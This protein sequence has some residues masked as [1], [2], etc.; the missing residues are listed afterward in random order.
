MKNTDN[1]RRRISQSIL[2]LA[3]LPLISGWPKILLASESETK[4]KLADL[5]LQVA[6]RA[7]QLRQARP[8]KL[9]I[10]LP[11]GSTANVK[12]A[13]DEFQ[14]LTGV[15]FEI[16]ETPVD[17]INTR[18]FLEA[19]LSRGSYDIALPA[20]FGIPDLAEAGAII[21]LDQYSS[22]YEPTDF[23]SNSLYTIGDY[24]RGQHYGYQTDGDTYLMFYNKRFLRN[25][26][27]SKSF[28]DKHGY[29][30]D[31]P[32]TWPELDALMAHFHQPE[33]GAYGGAL[34]RTPTYMLWEWWVRFHAKGFYPL[35]DNL[36]PQINNE[37]G[38][39]ALEEMI[40]ATEY[41]TPNARSNSL[42][43]NWRE[44]SRGNIFCNIGW[45][46]TQKY[47]N[48]NRSALLGELEFGPTPGGMIDGK[49]IKTSY[50]NWGWNY[51]VAT[52]SANPEIAYLFSLFA[53]SPHISTLAVR[54][55]DGFFDPF[56]TEHY[57]DE[58][59]LKTYSQA[60]LTEHHKSMANSIPDL[61]LNGQTQY[62]DALRNQI[63]IAHD[64]EKTARQ[65]LDATAKIWNRLHF[66]LGKKVQQ[67]QWRFLK[68][69]YPT[70]LK[71]ALR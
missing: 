66:K 65:A 64:G 60:F 19:Q 70:A 25:P 44:F 68:S 22:R 29:E 34:F 69:R 61:Y 4:F 47:L 10:L 28:A 18:M 51:T 37:A 3:G 36:K 30:A 31:I 17:D 52:N 54:E 23:Q 13:I 58:S 35:D 33:Q 53:C 71:F 27:L 39:D 16:I 9:T 42:F 14:A 45:G 59:I 57:E 48:S 43:D 12:P 15:E 56:R 49:S 21:P 8:V 26:Q 40:A 62:Y 24:Y 46:G 38:V 50:F 32:R 2:G 67:E 7:A 55:Q 41:L 5:H 11:E 1:N 6:T 63:A 20:T